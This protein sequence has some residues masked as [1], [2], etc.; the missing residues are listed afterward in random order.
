MDHAAQLQAI[1]EN[2]LSADGQFVYGV[3]TTGVYCRPSCKSRAPK[4]INITLFPVSE[5][6]EQAGYRACRKCHP[7]LVA[8]VSTSNS[9]VHEVC[10]YLKQQ[11]DAETG[12]K[13]TL[14]DIADHTGYSADY[15]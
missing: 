11:L 6:A 4:Q 14:G 13:V 5:A 1:F 8:P 2:D 15:I 9:V 7:N 3:K 12:K 10:V